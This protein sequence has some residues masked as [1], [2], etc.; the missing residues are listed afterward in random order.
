MPIEPSTYTSGPLSAQQLNSDMYTANATFTGAT[1]VL[2]HTRRPLLSETVY[3]PGTVYT[4]LYHGQ[5]ATA[6]IQAYSVIDNTAYYGI[7]ADSPGVYGFFRFRNF[8]QSSAGTLGGYGGWWLTWEFP[9]TGAVTDPPG[10]VGAGLY[11]GGTVNYSNGVFQYG[12]TLHDNCPWYMDLVNAGWGSVSAYT[13]AFWWLSPSVPVIEANSNDS[14]GLTTRH[15]WLWQGVSAGGSIVAGVPAP[16]TSWGTVTSAALNQS[17]GSCLT[18]LNNPPLL[19]VTAS[20]SQVFTSGG[21]GAVLFPGT[22]VVDN[23]NGWSTAT[24]AYTAPLPG[25]YLF[26]PM[27][28]WGTQS[29]TGIRLSGLKTSAG[30]TGVGQFYQ[31]PV[32][33]ATPV[34]PGVTGVGMTGTSVVRVLNLDAGDTVTDYGLQNSGISVSLLA[35]YGARLIG[36]YLGQVAASGTV[37]SYSVPTPSFRWQAGA[38]AGTALTAALE[39]YIGNDISFLMNKPYF[40]GYQATAQTFGTA[41][42]FNKVV[43]DTVGTLPRSGNGDNYGG[44]NSSANL[45]ESQVAGWYLSIADLYATPPVS[46]TVGVLTAG[47]SVATS[48]GITPYATPDQYQQLYHPAVGGPSPG[49]TAIGMYYLEPGETIYPVMQAFGWG[50]TWGTHVSAVSPYIYSQFSCFWVSS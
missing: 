6:G 47:F 22:P 26:C 30:G 35:S 48:G 28:G 49:V 3:A 13:P 4:S 16:S 14:S 34:G 25:L 42:T 21:T 5:I 19:R 9:Y 43:I 36:A 1:G 11:I 17:I 12:S 2:F 18:L 24:S 39:T 44:W 32:Y 33:Q 23:Y 7:G 31:G 20:S 46:G 29:S 8:V 10:G 15:G 45:Y 37:L 50:G 38:L 27:T 40:T 41:A